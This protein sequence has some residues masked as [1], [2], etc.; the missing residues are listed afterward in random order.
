MASSFIKWEIGDTDGFWVKDSLMQV[1]CWG[2]INV[3]D[4]FDSNDDD[5]LKIDAREHFYNVSQGIFVGFIS[6]NLD[7][8]LISRER[9]NTFNKIID[10]TRLL[11]QGIGEYIDVD[12]LNDFQKIKETRAVWFSPLET[13]LLIR[14]LICISAIVNHDIALLNANLREGF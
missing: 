8:Y 5:W 6:L 2:M 14:V 1:V 7:E 4:R 12:T 13:E 11:F 10:E 9:I 3:I